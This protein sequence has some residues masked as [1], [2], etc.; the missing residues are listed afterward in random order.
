MMEK[1]AIRVFKTFLFNSSKETT[2]KVSHLLW[3]TLSFNYI[4]NW[5]ETMSAYMQ[6][7]AFA[8]GKHT[9]T[10]QVIFTFYIKISKRPCPA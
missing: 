4:W 5:K 8:L 9:K 3:Y 7:V 10:L 6:H 1:C 2:M